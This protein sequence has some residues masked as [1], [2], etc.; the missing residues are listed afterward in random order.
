MP[1]PTNDAIRFALKQSRAAIGTPSDALALAHLTQLSDARNEW[2][3]PSEL[4]LRNELLAYL[5]ARLV[6]LH[7]ELAGMRVVNR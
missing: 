6:H 4:G 2:G 1:Q 5:D 7:P 3:Y